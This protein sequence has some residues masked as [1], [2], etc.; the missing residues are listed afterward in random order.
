MSGPE[1]RRAASRTLPIRA[2]V[3]TDRSAT[4]WPAAPLID[5]R[6]MSDWLGTC[7]REVRTRLTEDD[8]GSLWVLFLDRPGGEVLTAVAFDDAM[9]HIDAAMTGNLQR[10]INA[11]SAPAVLLV[12]PR[13][14]GQPGNSEI[15]LWQRLSGSRCLDTELI[16]LLAV[17]KDNHWSANKAGL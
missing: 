2:A 8:E 9:E 14:D 5:A 3:S 1:A 10:L 7:V 6:L 15:E 13:V 11:V 4:A 17:G 16:D 12:V